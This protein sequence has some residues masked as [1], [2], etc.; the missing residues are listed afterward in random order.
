[1]SSSMKRGF[2][3]AWLSTRRSSSAGIVAVPSSWRIMA[4]LSSSESRSSDTRWA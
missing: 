3:S 1:M 4:W 2:P